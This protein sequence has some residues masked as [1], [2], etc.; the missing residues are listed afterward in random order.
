M[1]LNLMSTCHK[2][3]GRTRLFSQGT[4]AKKARLYKFYVAELWS[5]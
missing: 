1:R 3:R 4:W 5:L 2:E